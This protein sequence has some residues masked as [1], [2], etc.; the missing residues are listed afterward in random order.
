MDF[1]RLYAAAGLFP[2]HPVEC[3]YALTMTRSKRVKGSHF[4]NTSA[5]HS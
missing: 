2:S 1:T 3:S 4:A 5:I